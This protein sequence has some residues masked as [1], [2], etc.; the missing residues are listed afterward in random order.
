[1]QTVVSSERRRERESVQSRIDDREQAWLEI[2]KAWCAL[3][4]ERNEDQFWPWLLQSKSFNVYGGVLSE[5]TCE[6][7]G[8]TPPHIDI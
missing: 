3:L 5:P 6:A 1:M 8:S 4:L 7:A 2:W